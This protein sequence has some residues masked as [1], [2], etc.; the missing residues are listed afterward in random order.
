MI[1]ALAGVKKQIEEINEYEKKIGPEC[2][3]SQF[4]STLEN[5][6]KLRQAQNA[7]ALAKQNKPNSS[8]NK[9]IVEPTDA[10]LV[11]NFMEWM[12]GKGFDE[13]KCKVK[14]DRNLSEGTGLVATQDI[15]EGEDF[16]EIPNNTFITTF[17]AFEGLGKPQVLENDRLIQSIP[18]IL[19]SIFLV[20]ELSN[21]NSDW[22][23]YIKVLPKQYN[24]V[25]YWGLKEFTQLRGSPSL[26]YAMRYVRGAMRQY[27]YL[28]SVIDRTQSN[29][30]PISSFTW[31]AFVWAISTVQ[32][33][34]NPVYAGN[35]SIM[36]L[37]P[38]W[39]F[40]NHSSAGNKITSFYHPETNSM[41]SGAIKD[42]KKGE[43]V[44]MFYGPRDNTQLLMHAGFATKTNLHDSYP[45]ELH[46]LE[47]NHEIRHDK[48]HLLEERGIRDNIVVN[49]NQNPSSNE[50]PLELIPFYRIYALSE[51]ETR[52]I[53]PPQVPGE[54]NHHHSQNLELKP[55]AFQILTKENEEKAY[56]NLLQALKGKLSSYPTTLEEDEQELKKNPPADQRFILYHKI[57][58][59]KILDRNIKYIESLVKKGVMNVTFKLP[60]LKEQSTTDDHHEHGDNCNHD[61]EESH[62]HS[63]G[64][65]DG[66][67]GHSHGGND[68]NHGHSHGGNGG[69]GHSHQ[70]GANCN[71]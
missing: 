47:G 20:K 61:H 35:G 49:L 10:Q 7:V 48:I 40:C 46:L 71:H 4:Q 59:K 54:H 44:Y 57:N 25:Y 13:T 3:L 36:A 8:G 67:H 51:Q 31:D 24:T 52:A 34:Q 27:C 62:G 69:H 38:F 63:H 1:K 15:K 70:H 42:F 16:V 17:V 56:A 22:A 18:G 14:I 37:I 60:E 28:Y 41:T 2:N 23:P 32:S 30:M 6:N 5:F 12:K 11:A 33:R 64:G 26:E 21:P 29:I 9:K 55:L 53:A 19:L 68:D 50:L 43:Q 65:K 39:D 58:E 66:S 45:F